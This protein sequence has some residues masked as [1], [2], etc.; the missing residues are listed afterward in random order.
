MKTVNGTICLEDIRSSSPEK[1]GVYYTESTGVRIFIPMDVLIRLY[2][3]TKHQISKSEN[4]DEFCN[5]LFK[6]E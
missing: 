6:K 1:E 4:W 5:N 3:M 2:D